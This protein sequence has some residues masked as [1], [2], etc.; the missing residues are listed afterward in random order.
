MAM[1]SSKPTTSAS[2]V[3]LTVIRSL[4]GFSTDLIPINENTNWSEPAGTS[5][6]YSP[7][8]SVMVPTVVP[9]TTTVTPGKGCPLGSAT[10]PLTL[11]T[12]D[13][14]K[15]SG[16]SSLFSTICRSLMTYLT[17]VPAK[18]TSSTSLIFLFFT[19]T[20]TVRSISIKF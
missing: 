6:T 3:T 2:M 12:C 18:T 20:L 19:E 7:L 5:N 4:I 15:K 10:L 14:P 11:R 9:F 13:T 1:T 16:L 17:S 8:S